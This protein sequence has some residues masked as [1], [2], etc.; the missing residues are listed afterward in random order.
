MGVHD[1]IRSSL[2]NCFAT[3]QLSSLFDNLVCNWLCS[4]NDVIH[5][6]LSK[7][8]MREEIFIALKT[9]KLLR[10]K[11]LMVCT[12]DFFQRFQWNVGDSLVMVVMDHF[13]FAIVPK[14]MNRTLI[15]HIPKGKFKETI[16]S[17][18]PISLYNTSV[19]AY[20]KFYQLRSNLNLVTLF[21]LSK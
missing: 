3:S 6:R 13:R 7:E 5:E 10:P 8:L 19:K 14:W 12:L 2:V 20:P 17:F 4:L 18:R 15:C 9:T 1:L 11:D 21:L 16:N